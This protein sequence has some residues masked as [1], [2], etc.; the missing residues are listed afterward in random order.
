MEVRCWSEKTPGSFFPLPRAYKPQPFFSCRQDSIVFF[1]VLSPGWHKISDCCARCKQA[2]S[3]WGIQGCL[4]FYSTS[5]P[6]GMQPKF[7]KASGSGGR[8]GAG[9]FYSTSSP[10]G[11]QPKYPKAPGRGGGV[12]VFFTAQARP[13]ACDQNFL[14]PPAAAWGGCVFLQFELAQRHAATW[15]LKCAGA[16]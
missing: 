1:P 6:S 4:H 13:A 3:L 11:M 7:S 5:S 15:G 9:Y 14:M 2:H 8:E 10:S 12:A 16:T